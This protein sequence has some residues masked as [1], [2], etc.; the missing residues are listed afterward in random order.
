VGYASGP[1][2]LMLE[3]VPQDV[4]QWR[5][6]VVGKHVPGPGVA[7]SLGELR[8]ALAALPDMGFTLRL[9]AGDGQ[10]V[11]LYSAQTHEVE[12]WLMP[13]TSNERG[14]LNLREPIRG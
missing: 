7:L 4:P 10:A 12:A 6:N 8:A 11:H 13:M 5:A 1:K 14:V 2:K 9:P 3:R